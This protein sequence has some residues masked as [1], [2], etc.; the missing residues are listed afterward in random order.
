MYCIYIQLVYEYDDWYCCLH[1]Q[2]V[3]EYY[4]WSRSLNNFFILFAN[5][6]AISPWKRCEFCCRWLVGMMNQQPDI[7]RMTSSSKMDMYDGSRAPDPP[8]YHAVS[9]SSHQPPGTTHHAG[10]GG[11]L[12]HFSPSSD[13]IFRP[14]NQS[15][16]IQTSPHQPAAG[17]YLGSRDRNL[18]SK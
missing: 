16:M 5:S 18:G 8:N 11:L 3:C 9:S 14:I 10:G 6:S 4:K 15:Y 1:I 12:Q 17:S 7:T 13:N 2:P